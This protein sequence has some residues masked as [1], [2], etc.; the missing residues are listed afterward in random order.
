MDP[1]RVTL[2][3]EFGT[4]SGINNDQQCGL[5]VGKSLAGFEYGTSPRVLSVVRSCS[6]FEV[7]HYLSVTP[8]TRIAPSN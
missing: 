3:R 1:K 5:L 7:N 8:S 6:D 2:N 4:E